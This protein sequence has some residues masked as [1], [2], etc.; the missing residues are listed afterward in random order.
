MSFRL[1]GLLV[2]RDPQLAI[3]YTLT[4]LTLALMGGGCFSLDAWLENRRK[5]NTPTH[6]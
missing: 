1:W 6:A 3:L 5:Q 2:D 4:I